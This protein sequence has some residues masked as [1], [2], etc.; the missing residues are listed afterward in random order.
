M[1][2]EVYALEVDEP[3]GPGETCWSGDLVLEHSAR[4]SAIYVAV[5]RVTYADGTTVTDSSP[6]YDSWGK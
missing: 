6:D 3:I 2:N 5:C 4:I 1:D